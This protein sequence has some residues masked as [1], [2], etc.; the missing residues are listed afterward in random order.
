[1]AYFADRCIRAH[2]CTSLC[3]HGAITLLDDGRPMTDWAICRERCYNAAEPPYACTTRCH[4]GARKTIGALVTVR[5]VLTEVLKD[6]S[7]YQESGGGITLSGGE[8]MNQVPFVR[9]LLCAAKEHWLHTAIE[10]CGYAAWTSFESVLEYV[11]FVFLDLKVLDPIRHEDLTGQGNQVILQNA[12][13]I[14][15]F[16]RRRGGR[17]VV[18]IPIVPGLTDSADNVE[19]IADFV[20]ERMPGVGTIELMPYH[21]LGRGKYADIGMTY[22]LDGLVPPTEGAMNRLREILTGR[23][24]TLTY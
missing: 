2:R 1:M 22:F 17:V 24:F 20:R 11:D 16:M 18:R 21:R 9:D 19:S 7:I 10:T 3:P 12:P 14:A 6:S 5:E 23:G 13:R 4:S 8:P 15:E